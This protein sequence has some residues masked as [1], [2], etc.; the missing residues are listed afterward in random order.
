MLCCTA[1]T[2]LDDLLSFLLVGINLGLAA[3]R[4]KATEPHAVLCTKVIQIG[5]N[6]SQSTQN[7]SKA[8]ALLLEIA[9]A[10]TFLFLYSYIHIPDKLTH[11]IL[12]AQ[13]QYTYI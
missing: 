11:G 2:L 3:G 10:G 9:K 1:W 12:L 7:M 8:I 4:K 5:S 13:Q 6:S